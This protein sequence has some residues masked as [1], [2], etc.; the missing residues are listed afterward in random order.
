MAPRSPELPRALMGASA[1]RS[2]S[3]QRLGVGSGLMHA[4]GQGDLRA[5]TVVS[6]ARR[7]VQNPQAGARGVHLRGPGPS[8]SPSPSCSRALPQAV[9]PSPSCCRPRPGAP[10][11]SVMI[12]RGRTWTAA[13]SRRVTGHT[14][15]DCRPLSTDLLSVG[16]TAS[17]PSC[18]LGP[19]SQQRPA[20]CGEK[21]WGEE[22]QDDIGPFHITRRCSSGAGVHVLADQRCHGTRVGEGVLCPA[23]GIC[24]KL[25]GT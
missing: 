24:L 3:R 15:S 7:T 1:L 13:G 25:S 21:N 16:D 8:A 12:P 11:I 4:V 6:E 9:S 19:L 22:T 23:A 10:S 2:G 5:L 20:F 14:A 18:P 17:E